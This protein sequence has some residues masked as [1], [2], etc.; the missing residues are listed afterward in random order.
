[1]PTATF[2]ELVADIYQ[3]GPSLLRLTELDRLLRRDTT[4]EAQLLQALRRQHRQ[5]FFASIL[6]LMSEQ[7]LLTEGFMPCKPLDNRT[8]QQLRQ[9]L[10]NRLKL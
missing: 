4:D 6:Q 8:T 9:Q 2:T 3:N 7:T 1:M 5:S 10:R